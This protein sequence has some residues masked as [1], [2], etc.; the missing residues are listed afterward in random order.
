MTD[1]NKR[2]SDILEYV[3]RNDGVG[4]R[5][6]KA[7]LEERGWKMTRLTIIRDTKNLLEKKLIQK[8]GKGRN[9]KYTSKEEKILKYFNVSEYFKKNTDERVAIENFNFE[10]YK[11]L[12]K[13]LGEDESAELQELND[14][15]RKRIK[16]LPPAII[17]KEFERLTIELSWKSSQIEG[18]T[19]SLLET[20]TLIKERE[21]AKGHKKEEAVQ[22]LN[23]KKALDYILDKKSDFKKITMRK[24]EN[25]HELIVKNLGVGRGLRQRP[26]GITGTAYRPLDN[27]HQIREAMQKFVKVLNGIKNPFT[28]AIAAVLMISYVQPF[29]DGNKR[30][31]RL[32]GNAIFL[33]HGIC[34]LSFRSISSDEYKKAII[35]FYEQN[36]AR[37]FKELFIE[38]FKFAIR[39]YF[40]A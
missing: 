12:K 30:T 15:Y 8:M 3:S 27:E 9:V 17:K 34:P 37:Y 29:E 28:K 20:E 19:Y 18:N 38:Q 23:H 22:I 32:L 11:D 10:I 21:E 24:I 14:G 6:I 4:V 13:I 7:Y 1:L 39:N 25:I 40:L 16:K 36:S 31:A 35:L 2:Q 5:E 33:S 26:V